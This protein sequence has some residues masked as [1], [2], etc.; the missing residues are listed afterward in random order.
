MMTLRHEQRPAGPAPG[1]LLELFLHR[2][3][4][5]YVRMLS[6]LLL[7]LYTGRAAADDAKPDYKTRYRVID[8]HNH[9]GL[10]TE[11]AVKAEL[12]VLDRAGVHSA[13]I[14]DGGSP[15]GSLPAWLKLQKQFPRIIVFYKLS[16]EDIK[17]PNFFTD[18]VQDLERAARGGV[19]GVKVWKDLGMYVRDG[20]GKLLKAD[21]DR[22]DPFWDKCAE[23][24]LPVLIHSADPREYWYPLTYNSFHYGLRN[25]KDQHYNNAEMPRW[26]E[27]LRQRD[28]ILK[29][30]PK[31]MF[32]GAHFGSETFDL[33]QLGETLEK[34]PNFH[35]D[36]SARLRILGRLNPPAVRDFFVKY[37]DRIL[38]GSDNVILRKGKKEKT[39]SNISEYPGDDPDFEWLKTDDLTAVRRWQDGTVHDYGQYLQYFETDKLDITDP[40][41][42]GGAWLRIP[43]AKLPPDVL[44]KFYH[45]NAEKLIPGLARKDEKP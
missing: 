23:L 37:Q 5:M 34:Y 18:V 19:R 25:E 45:A 44:E 40:S 26:E 32:I 9:C 2:E 11:S 20:S 41:H 33:K 10:A 24:G 17:K 30:H 12:E 3:P 21:D 35:V 36:C 28:Q 22:L 14:L 16:F 6:C 4:L 42:S 39:S 27:L 43:G 38:F 31:T 7:I 29:K 13:V 15:R 1:R 8:V